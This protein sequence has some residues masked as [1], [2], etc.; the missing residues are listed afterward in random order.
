VRVDPDRHRALVRDLADRL[1]APAH[2]AVTVPAVPARHRAWVA[3][4][5]ARVA[6]E[7]HR[8]GYPV[9]GDLDLVARAGRR[10]GGPP[11][12]RR[13]SVELALAAVLDLAEDPRPRQREDTRR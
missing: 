10:A 5:A 7:L 2:G 4:H 12:Q 9:H 8:G 13:A 3:E 11:A 6:D 1:A